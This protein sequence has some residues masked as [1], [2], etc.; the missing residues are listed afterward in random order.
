[1]RDINALVVKNFNDNILYIQANHKKLFSD[2]SALDSA[3]DKGHYQEKYELKYENDYFDVYE[4]NRDSYLYT[5]DSSKH[6]SLVAQ[7]INY[8]L[9]ENI[10]KSFHEHKISDDNLEKYMQMPPF[11]HEMSGHA[12]IIHYTQQHSLKDKTLKTLDKFVF[13]GVGL[14]LHIESIHERIS[15][16]AYLIIE[17][18]LELFRLSLFTTNYASLAKESKLFFSVFEQNDEFQQTSTQFLE[19]KYYYNHYI[20]YF[21]ILSHNEK[22]IDLFQIAIASQSHLLFYYSTLL[23]QFIRP[24]SYMFEGYSFLDK[25]ISFNNNKLKR[26]PFLILGAGPSLEKNK[27]WLKKNQKNFIIVAVS[28][29]LQFLEKEN[30]AP[31]IIVQLD[32]FDTSVKFFDKIKSTDFIKES[33]FLLSD[34]VSSKIVSRLDKKRVFFFENGT[35]YKENSLKPSAPCVGS[36]SYQIL[37]FLKVNNIYLLGI[38]LAIDSKTGSTHSGSHIYS[39][40]I[41]IEEHTQ[42]SDLFTY[43]RTLLSIDGNLNDK[44]LTTAQ[45]HISIDTINQ[46]TKLLKKEFQQIYN[47]SDGA[48]FSDI[49]PKNIQELSIIDRSSKKE[50]TELIHKVCLENSSKEISSSELRNLEKKLSHAKKLQTIINKYKQVNNISS[51]IYLEYLTALSLELTPESERA[52]YELSRVI[53]TYLQYVLAYIFDFFNNQNLDDEGTNIYNL[54]NILTTHLLEIITYYIN[55]VDAIIDKQQE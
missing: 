13:F 48:M 45:L 27:E 3:I 37:L 30:I 47:L 39:D 6:A 33:I 7:S 16:K 32:A 28:A 36:I 34:R 50:S 26:Q 25:T 40:N 46:S 21:H 1:M 4:K 23:T 29:T 51:S 54:H 9:D 49:T 17:D 43:D 5:K 19:Y 31:D 14:G 18:D 42:K 24:L 52:L 38:D 41:S 22:K 35:T 11:E 2:L 15:A 12:P 53:E 8:K 55:S 10:F 44:V 20:K